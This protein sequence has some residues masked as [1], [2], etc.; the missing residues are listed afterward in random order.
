MWS[1]ASNDIPIGWTLCNG[2]NGTPDLQNRFII[3]AGSTYAVNATGGSTTKTI[4]MS[5]LPA[6]NHSAFISG[7]SCA[8]AGAH[9][10]NISGSISGGSVYVEISGGNI[11]I[12]SALHVHTN[13]V[14]TYLRI[15]DS[16]SAGA[17]PVNGASPSSMSSVSNGAHKHSITGGTVTVNNTGSGSAFDIMPPY[18]TLCFIMKLQLSP[19]GDC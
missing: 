5:N 9:T 12:N 17:L 18:Y 2:S 7:I 11:R 6:H 3:G 8:S 16:S 14:G 13:G 1:D 15:D 19:N 4:S 10:H